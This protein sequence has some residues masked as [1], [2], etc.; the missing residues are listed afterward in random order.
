MRGA[1][2]STAHVTPVPFEGRPPCNAPAYL[3]T[4]ITV[5][6]G[7]ICRKAPRRVLYHG[8]AL[9]DVFL[10]DTGLQNA[11]RRTGFHL[12][13]TEKEYH[14]IGSYTMARAINRSVMKIESFHVYRVQE[15]EAIEF[16]FGASRPFASWYRTRYV[17][18][19]DRFTL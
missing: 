12:V 11:L 5:P 6:G 16:V 14:P 7:C 18:W 1:Y 3:G 8:K 19:P 2:Y 9:E 10:R 4:C 15:G 13:F 17:E